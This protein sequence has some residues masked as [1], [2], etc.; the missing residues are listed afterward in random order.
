MFCLA[1][2]EA[3]AGASG[4]RDLTEDGILTKV[5]SPARGALVMSRA[6]GGSSSQFILFADFDVTQARL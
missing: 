4:D 1:V 5:I 3:V 6:E 2:G